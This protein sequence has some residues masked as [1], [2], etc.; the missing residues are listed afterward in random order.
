MDIF[1]KSLFFALSVCKVFGALLRLLKSQSVKLYYANVNLFL[2]LL[3][4]FNG[5]LMKRWNSWYIASSNINEVT[6]TIL[7]SFIQKFRNHKQ[8]QNAYKQIKT[9]KYS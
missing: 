8:A 5:V 6:R 9:K 3:I 1:L 7:N 2:Y 4:H